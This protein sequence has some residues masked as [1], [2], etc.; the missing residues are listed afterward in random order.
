MNIFDQVKTGTLADPSTLQGAILY[1]IVFAF[2]AWLIGSALRLAVQR[3]LAHD[4][5]DHVDQMAVKFLA[6]L[7]RFGVYIFAFI[8]YARLVPA[9]AGLSAASLASVSV[10][11]VI[12]GLAAQNTLGNLIAGL[13]LLL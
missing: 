2:L 1:A 8:S 6:K 11:S 10:I 3:V 5:H 4:K 13:S 9:L 7:V 12:V